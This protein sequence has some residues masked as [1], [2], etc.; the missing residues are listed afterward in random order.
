MEHGDPLLWWRLEPQAKAAALGYL[1]AT[2]AERQ[3]E[4][5]R[6]KSS[7]RGRVTPDWMTTGSQL[8]APDLE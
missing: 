7:K 2:G 8:F 3:E 4:H 1:G 5:R 6:R